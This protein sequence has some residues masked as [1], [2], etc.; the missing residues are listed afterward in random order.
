LCA[1]G[2]ALQSSEHRKQGERDSRFFRSHSPD[3]SS[4]HQG[5]RAFSDPPTRL[6]TAKTT[7]W[8]VVQVGGILVGKTS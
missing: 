4:V 7:R 2:T 5:Q 6:R 3:S 1:G 8:K